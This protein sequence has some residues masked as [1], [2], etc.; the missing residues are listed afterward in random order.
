MGCSCGAF[1]VR[2]RAGSELCSQME[3]VH[4]V[5]QPVCGLQNINTVW[6]WAPRCFHNPVRPSCC[7]IAFLIWCLLFPLCGF[8][9]W[10]F[11]G[12]P[13]GAGVESSELH[14][15][16]ILEK[17][18]TCCFSPNLASTL[19]TPASLSLWSFA[20][21]WTKALRILLKRLRLISSALFEP[22]YFFFPDAFQDDSV[23]LSSLF[24]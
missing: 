17:S 22:R 19:T 12:R 5:L 10:V 20:A 9:S 11:P 13:F 6:W 23:S 16:L 21:F 15:G 8:C 2:S 24:L 3:A 7:F 14:V 4:D 18:H 1:A